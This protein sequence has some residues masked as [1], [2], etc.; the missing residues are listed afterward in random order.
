M[1][2]EEIEN[3]KEGGGVKGFRN[4]RLLWEK[5]CCSLQLISLFVAYTLWCFCNFTVSH[6][7]KTW[8]THGYDTLYRNANGQIQKAC[9]LRYNHLSIWAN[10]NVCW[11]CWQHCC[12]IQS[13]KTFEAKGCYAPYPGSGILMSIQGLS[14]AQS[15]VC[16]Q[17]S[18]KVV[19]WKRALCI[20]I[21]NCLHDELDMVHLPESVE[22]SWQE[23]VL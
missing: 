21:H 20:S 9:Y 11:E 6:L 16:Y 15:C 23:Y 12:H 14:C 18:E 8:I 17:C 13:G 5:R 1:E 2:M 4:D 10:V 7:V 22:T 3:E 19:I